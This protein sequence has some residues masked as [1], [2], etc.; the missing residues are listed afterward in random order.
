MYMYNMK[1]LFTGLAEW[2][3]PSGGMFIWF[4]LNVE[5]TFELITVKARAKSVLFVPGNAFFVNEKDKSPYI[6]ASYSSC[7]EA[8]MDEV[9]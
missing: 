4:K 5:D 3:V 6:R 2:T 1:Y 9:C 7:T 8:Q